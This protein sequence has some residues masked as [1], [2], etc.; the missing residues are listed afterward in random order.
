MNDQQLYELAC[1]N[2]GPWYESLIGASSGARLLELDGVLATITPAVPDRSI[3]NGIVYENTDALT[4]NLDRL[5]AEYDEAGVTAWMVWVPEHD[6]PVASAL[7]QAGHK[8]D[9]APAAMALELAEFEPRDIS[10]FGISR[11]EDIGAICALNDHA[12]DYAEPAFAKGITGLPSDMR[13]YAIHDGDSMIAC[14]GSLDIDR[15][16]CGIF[17]VAT[18]AESR[19]RGF[20]GALMTHALIEARARGCNTTSLQATKAGYPIYRKLGYKDLGTIQ[21]WE[22]RQA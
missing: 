4:A 9:A 17:M 22:K 11:T 21:M 7:E 19:G 16:D 6:R 14:A 10:G 20:A 12:Y 5:G 15:D 3:L 18:H 1:R 8:L 13:F 2:L